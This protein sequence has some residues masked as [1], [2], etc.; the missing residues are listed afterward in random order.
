MVLRSPQLPCYAPL[1]LELKGGSSLFEGDRADGVVGE[2]GADRADGVLG[3]EGAGGV[4]VSG[5]R[6]RA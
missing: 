3:E 4:R 1:T 2:E 6:D 5:I